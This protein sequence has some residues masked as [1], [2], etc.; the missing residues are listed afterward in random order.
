VTDQFIM[1]LEEFQRDVRFN[2]TFKLVTD[3]SENLKFTDFD[4][5]LGIAPYPSSQ[6]KNLLK[7][8]QSQE[9]IDHQVVMLD[10]PDVVKFGGWDEGSM[11][12]GESLDLLKTAS[13]TEWL[14]EA[15]EVQILGKSISKQEDKL[16]SLAPHLDHVYVPDADWSQIAM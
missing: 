13:S 10:L 4:G 14:L 5:Y 9:L 11:A 12:D 8:L 7:Q 3:S 6:E 1:E 2:S 15:G 16:I